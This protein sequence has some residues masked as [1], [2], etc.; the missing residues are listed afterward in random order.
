MKNKSQ[1]KKELWKWF[2]LY[3]RKRDKWRCFTCGRLASGS[4]LHAGHFI[5]KSIGGLALYFNEDN[6]RA[7]CFNC[8]INLGGNSYVFGQ[9]LGP[10]M[11]KKLYA[12][13]GIET[14]W[15]INDYLT[16]IEYYKKL[17]TDSTW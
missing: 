2:S 15:E 16:K 3:I 6:V 7:Q 4:G 14:K 1:L 5:A 13:K 10:K 11:V 8:N 17:S 9:K 12:L